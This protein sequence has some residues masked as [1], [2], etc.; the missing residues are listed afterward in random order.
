M[1]S[2]DSLVTGNTVDTIGAVIVTAASVGFV[3]LC[4]T[5]VYAVLWIGGAGIA[6]FVGAYLYA[7]REDAYQGWR[8][9]WH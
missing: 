4:L 5:N 1:H 7:V 6:F 3:W 2:G 8:D 9:R